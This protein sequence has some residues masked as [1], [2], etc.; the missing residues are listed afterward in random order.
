MEMP[1]APLKR[2]ITLIALG[3]LLCSG[4]G[5]TA[6][7]LR[8]PIFYNHSSV[9]VYM[10]EQRGLAVDTINAGLPWPDGVNYYAYGPSV[11]PYNLNL[12]VQMRDARVLP[13]RVECRR[14]RF[15]CQLT[16]VDLGFDRTPMPDI[17]S[18]HRLDWPKWVSQLAANIGIQITDF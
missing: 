9:V 7:L 11:Y 12:E 18:S 3:I 6:A 16:I 14:D 15:D 13:G 17:N 4:G 2:L 1:S 8:P 5:I 10:I